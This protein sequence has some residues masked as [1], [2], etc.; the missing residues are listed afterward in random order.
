VRWGDTVS[1]SD[2]SLKPRRS[3]LESEGVAAELDPVGQ[4]DGRPKL[5]ISLGLT[6]TPAV[7]LK[8]PGL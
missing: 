2:V 7:A 6:R 3:T 5:S 4:P 8:P 1:A